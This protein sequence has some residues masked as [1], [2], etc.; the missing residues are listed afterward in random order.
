MEDFTDVPNN[1]DNQVKETDS[2]DLLP[3]DSPLKEEVLPPSNDHP[4]GQEELDKVR[5]KRG[6][7]RSEDHHQHL[8]HD[9]HL[10]DDVD[11][12]KLPVEHRGLD[13]DDDLDGHHYVIHNE[14]SRITN[15]PL[16]S[17]IIVCLSLI[18]HFF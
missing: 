4:D 2:V 15:S 10:Q 8:D 16:A 3:N 14:S 12:S 1:D 11:S 9:G 6:A 7:D 18:R 17:L 13:E 5:E